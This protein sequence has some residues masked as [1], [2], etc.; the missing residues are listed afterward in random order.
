MMSTKKRKRQGGSGGS[1][2]QR[3]INIGV[4]VRIR[5]FLPSERAHDLTSKLMKIDY[6]S[7][8]V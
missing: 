6:K 1:G 7:N 5:P 2:G 8:K 3:A 4:A